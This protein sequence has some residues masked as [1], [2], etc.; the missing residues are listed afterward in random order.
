MAIYRMIPHD[1]LKRIWD[2]FVAH[3]N[4]INRKYEAFRKENQYWWSDRD[5]LVGRFF[6]K[7]AGRYIVLADREILGTMQGNFSFRCDGKSMFSPEYGRE[8][9]HGVPGKPIVTTSRKYLHIGHFSAVNEPYGYG[10]IMMHCLDV[11]GNN[12]DLRLD[13]GTMK[14]MQFREISEEEFRSVASMFT[15]DRDDIPFKVQRFLTPE[16]SKERARNTKG[17]RR[18][19]TA[20]LEEEVVTVMARDAKEALGKV[21]NAVDV[22]YAGKGGPV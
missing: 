4:S 17:R 16:E 5:R 20:K 9:M 7:Y 18:G 19:R 10:Y 12:V 22:W 2:A 6:A 15:D 11:F 3:D 13:W 1:T 21:T 8:W 14:D